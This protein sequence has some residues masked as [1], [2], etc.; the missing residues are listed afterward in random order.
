MG[1]GFIGDSNERTK[2]MKTR[3]RS[4]ATGPRSSATVT[5]FADPEGVKAEARAGAAPGA[6]AGFPKKKT[7]APAASAAAAAA[8]ENSFNA[9]NVDV[10]RKRDGSELLIKPA[11]QC[12]GIDEAADAAAPIVV[13]PKKAKMEISLE[14]KTM[15]GAP[16]GD[17]YDIKVLLDSEL[18]PLDQAHL[19]A[20]Q[21]RAVLAS[22]SLDTSLWADKYATVELIRRVILFH[23]DVLRG[24]AVLQTASLEMAV[25]AIQSLRSCSV[26]NGILCLK[27]VVASLPEML[28]EPC[29]ASTL[30]EALLARSAAGP[31]FVCESAA[32]AATAAAART[33]SLVLLSA[34]SSSTSHRNAEVSSL[35]HS[36]LAQ[37]V[38]RATGPAAPAD[39]AT[40]AAAATAASDAVPVTVPVGE[41]AESDLLGLTATLGR[42]LDAK[43][44]AARDQSRAA[45]LGLGA[46]LGEGR[47]DELAVRALSPSQL[48]ELRRR[49]EGGEA[50]KHAAS[51]LAGAPASSA[52]GIAPRLAVA[53]EGLSGTAAGGGSSVAAA[54][55]KPARSAPLSIKEQMLMRRAQM[56]QQQQQSSSSS[57]SSEDVFQF[58]AAAA[59][60]APVVAEASA[61]SDSVPMD[62]AA[63]TEEPAQPAPEAQAQVQAEA[64]DGSR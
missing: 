8:D 26:R 19:V 63:P 54:Q 12:G 15:N 35:A 57:S 55:V 42:G 41:W 40:T 47:F 23:G 20:D 29:H 59:A 52:S 37:S 36:L 2:G 50:P 10:N 31:R 43:R 27:A 16:E 44:P 9:T 18:A 14:E 38:L 45:L 21:L 30:L 1:N 56:Q 13:A 51:V 5:V 4:S 3:S 17:L 64:Q 11:L 24:D 7:K 48:V 25:Q 49:R 22:S 61:S 33:P 39:A 32:D 28:L 53:S 46:A 60:A 62:V 58:A 6:T 34:L